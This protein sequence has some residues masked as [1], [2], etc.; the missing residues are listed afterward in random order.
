MDK[1]NIGYYESNIHTSKNKDSVYV[2]KYASQQKL[3]DKLQKE[4][5]KQK[6]IIKKIKEWEQN[7]TILVYTK[8]APRQLVGIYELLHLLYDD[9]E[10]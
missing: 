3:I 1:E 2:M 9:E 10:E 8:K 4:N 6:E 5:Q 7:H